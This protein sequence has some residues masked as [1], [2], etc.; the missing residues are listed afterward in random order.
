M[1]RL[2]ALGGSGAN[3]QA[4]QHR[5]RNTSVEVAGQRSSSGLHDVKHALI[6][7]QYHAFS[8]KGLPSGA[9]PLRSDSAFWI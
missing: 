2:L 7:T 5:V 6:V 1:A 3:N 8:K 4:S 9:R